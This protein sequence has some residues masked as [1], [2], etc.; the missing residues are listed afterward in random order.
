M[1][2]FFSFLLLL[3]LV[4]NVQAQ[5]AKFAPAMG[6]ALQEMG[7]VA[8]TA[9][10]V[11]LAAK[12][13][14]IA[15]AEKDQWLPYYYAGL[16]LVLAGFADEKSNRDELG[17]RA[18]NLMDKAMALTKSSE[19]YAVKSMSA[20]LQMMVNPMER[21]QTFG[22]KS[23]QAIKDGM[24]INPNN[25]RLYYLQ[26]QTLLNT[27]EAFGGG[28]AVAQPMF[29]KALELYEKF[30]VA[31]PLDPSWGKDQTLSGLARCKA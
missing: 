11:A 12:F 8:T 5:S 17:Q 1:K 20:T 4:G 26:A 10:R 16:N 6:A 21:W 31:S 30:P 9:D 3:S 19:P 25:P 29:E 18:S 27:P 23:T 2:Q 15:E 14:R 24:A 7:T 22:T 13:E 28:K